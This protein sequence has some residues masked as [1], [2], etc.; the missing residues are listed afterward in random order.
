M[1]GRCKK[2]TFVCLYSKK[3]IAECHVLLQKRPDATDE[4][5]ITFLGLQTSLESCCLTKNHVDDG[6]MLEE[7]NCK[8]SNTAKKIPIDKETDGGPVYHVED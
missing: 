8:T 7:S 4:V 1:N 2:K 6:R 3:S 5:L